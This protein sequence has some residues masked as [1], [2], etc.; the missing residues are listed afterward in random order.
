MKSIIPDASAEAIDLI[1]NLLQLD[2]SKRMRAEDCLKHPF[3]NRQGSEAYAAKLHEM[4]WIE[5][6]KKDLKS[7]KA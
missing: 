3:F 6:V 4:D 7:T 1:E 2:P 5:K